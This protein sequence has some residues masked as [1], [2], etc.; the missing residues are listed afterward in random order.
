MER[1]IYYSLT[2]IKEQRACP[3][4]PLLFEVATMLLET[5]RLLLRP[6]RTGDWAQV[7]A[8]ARDPET[9]RL[10]DW[11]P[12]SQEECKARIVAAVAQNAAPS[13]MD[14]QLAAIFRAT[15]AL[16]GQARL[17]VDPQDTRTAG[18]E[19]VLHRLAW[20]QG[21][22]T[23][24]AQSLVDH[25]FRSLDI[26]RIRATCRTENA[27]FYRVLLKAGLRLEEYQ[28][29]RRDA[30]G[31]VADAFICTITREDWLQ[32]DMAREERPPV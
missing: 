24:I 29:N 12:C 6:F 23:E 3:A 15:G 18:L 21:F 19:V 25:G 31:Q 5:P 28:Q 17:A 7:H 9:V 10:L 8:Y 22:A 2:A 27:A 11:G 20:G 32:P 14:H 16:V 13:C 30:R 4:G 1:G 26:R